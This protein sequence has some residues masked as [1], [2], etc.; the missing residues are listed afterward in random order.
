MST[1]LSP[2]GTHRNVGEPASSLPEGKIASDNSSGGRGTEGTPAVGPALSC[3]VSRVTPAAASKPLEGA[4]K[5]ASLA[6]ETV[7]R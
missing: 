5:E 7:A 6:R 4:G 3:G 1:L 2:K